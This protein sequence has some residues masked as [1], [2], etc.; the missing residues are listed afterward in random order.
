MY[1]YITFFFFEVDHRDNQKI[2]EKDPFCAKINFNELALY[3][4]D[5]LAKVDVESWVKLPEVCMMIR[6]ATRRYTV[7]YD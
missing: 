7:C 4:K 2:T 3:Q 6:T 5:K 1:R